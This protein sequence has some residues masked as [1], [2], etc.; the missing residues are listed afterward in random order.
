MLNLVYE[1]EQKGASLRVLE[2]EFCTSGDTGRIMATVLGMVA[3]MERKFI[4][5]KGAGRDRRG[6][7]VSRMTVWRS[8][9]GR[10]V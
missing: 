9:N 10:A 1:L 8:L 2:P 6:L 5:G 7:G 4:Q 3:E